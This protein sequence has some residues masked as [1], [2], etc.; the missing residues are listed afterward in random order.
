MPSSSLRLSLFVVL[1]LHACDSTPSDQ[2]VTGEPVRGN[3]QTGSLDSLPSGMAARTDTL[4]TEALTCSPSTLRRGD[5]V[6]LRMRTPHA[7][8][9]GVDHPD[10]TLF[11]IV[12][13]TL[14]DSTRKYSAMPSESFENVAT[15]R[16]PADIKAH[17]RVV[18][19]E[20]VEP[21]FTRSGNYT[22]MLGE[23]ETDHG[24]PTVRCTV[25]FEDKVP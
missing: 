2:R 23:L 13:P 15:F 11:F 4:I 5:S 7:S 10:G 25:R 16:I 20:P 22:V 12:Y 8:Y 21:L 1:C 9:L 18:G 6:T 17:P 24:P 3:P 14:G 19:R